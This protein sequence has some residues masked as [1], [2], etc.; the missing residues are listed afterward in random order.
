MNYRNIAYDH[1][2]LDPWK[3]IS[4]GVRYESNRRRRNQP[5]STN[6]KILIGLVALLDFLSTFMS[7]RF[8]AHQDDDAA[9]DHTKPASSHLRMFSQNFF[10][11]FSLLQEFCFWLARYDPHIGFFFS[12]LWCIDAIQIA[13]KQADSAL[14]EWERRRFLRLFAVE[15]E[16]TE[17][18]RLSRIDRY[19]TWLLFLSTLLLQLL[20]L[21]V[22]FYLL[23]YKLMRWNNVSTG[24]QEL[25]ALLESTYQNDNLPTEYRTFTNETMLSLGFAVAKHG[26][27]AV[28]KVVNRH[29]KLL[30]REG[31][32]KGIRFGLTALI[33]PVKAWNNA[34]YILSYMRWVKYIMPAISYTI[35]I[36]A[37]LRTMIRTYKQRG[38]RRIAL[39]ERRKQW[40]I[41]SEE[42]R[43]IRATKQIQSTF[44]S[45]RARKFCLNMMAEHYNQEVVAAHTLQRAFRWMLEHKKVKEHKK[46]I[47]LDELTKLERKRRK[48]GLGRKNCIAAMPLE[49]VERLLELRN[50]IDSFTHNGIDAHLLMR[51]DSG[52]QAVWATICFTLTLLE[53]IAHFSNAYMAKKAPDS[54]SALTVSTK[55]QNLLLPTAAVAD[56]KEC[57]CIRSR[58]KRRRL[59]RRL[60]AKKCDPIGSPWY[61]HQTYSFLEFAYSTT[62]LFLIER[63]TTIMGIVFFWDVPVLFFTGRYHPDTGALTSRPFIR[64]W[65]TPGLAM[66]LI[67]NPK[68][69]PVAKVLKKTMKSSFEIGPIRV[70]RWIRTL[71]Y[72]LI[73]LLLDLGERFLLIPLVEYANR[74]K[75]KRAQEQDLPGLRRS[76]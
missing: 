71:L 42:R 14:K 45:Y 20:F 1:R 69:E 16:G 34:K 41:M 63:I 65:I 7:P 44:R 64:R 21:P 31:V 51:P 75:P 4:S 27:K 5:F 39:R 49:E 52:F 61:C 2:G 54:A 48:P 6:W 59:F 72:P 17:L 74:P 50:K 26:G 25:T 36:R 58:P 62:L 40:K 29:R 76:S 28:A 55:L 9:D 23:M 30:K 3:T 70:W 13:D 68:M 8:F 38:Q 37:K 47:E 57:S 12:I 33:H 18:P 56:L 15:K 73:V 10:V 43:K 32:R 24:P 46:Q 35:R 19:K 22:G 66:Q 11:P 53:V 67:S 60:Q